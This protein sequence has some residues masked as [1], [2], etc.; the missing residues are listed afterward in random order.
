MKAPAEL[1]D[2]CLN[3]LL[4]HGVANLSLRPMA[5]KVGTSARMLLHHFGSKERLIATVMARVRDDLQSSFAVDASKSSSPELILKFWDR[6][7]RKDRLPYLRLL[8]E[9]QVLAIQNPR[10]YRRY[11]ADTSRSWLRIV[12]R[13][14]PG[15][16]DGAAFATVNTAVIDGLLLEL[17]SSGDSRRIRRALSQYV[18]LLSRPHAA[19]AK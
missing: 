6:I 16:S 11:L 5:A 14:S 15:R 18:A 19:V 4:R 1:I 10:R 3:Y 2:R 12:Q 9:V 7:T 8:L 13:S 17:L